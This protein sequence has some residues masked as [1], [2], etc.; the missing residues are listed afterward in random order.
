[1]DSKSLDNKDSCGVRE[2]TLDYKT[3]NSEEKMY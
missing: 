2:G 1:M 3:M